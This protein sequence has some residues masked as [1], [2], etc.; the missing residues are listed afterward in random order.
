MLRLSF[1]VQ[2]AYPLKDEDIGREKEMEEDVREEK[3]N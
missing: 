3:K 1:S 2:F